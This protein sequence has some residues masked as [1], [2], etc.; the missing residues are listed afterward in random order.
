MQICG[1]IGDRVGIA[2]SLRNQALTYEDMGK[3]EQA[4]ALLRD[5][6]R[7][8]REL[9]NKVELAKCMMDQ[10]RI[11]Q[12]Q[13]SAKAELKALRHYGQAE[14]IYR[15]IGD[16][17]GLARCL[18]GVS[19][20]H[21]LLEQPDEALACLNEAQ[22]IFRERGNHDGYEACLLNRAVVMLGWD[23]WIGLELLLAQEVRLR[24]S[25]NHVYLIQCLLTQLP[26]LMK[27]GKL[28]EAMEKCIESETLCR[29]M[30]DTRRL[31]L[32]LDYQIKIREC[33]A[34]G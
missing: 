26:I 30:G 31:A 11:V 27:Q 16:R 2:R 23:D 18:H 1:A 4:L 24:E 7:V 10:A 8:C 14:A 3:I 6:E 22:D 29:K 21:I 9:G 20:I 13:G 25:G 12:E 28:V 32:S 17:E 33:E 5:S 34:A 15:D 19:R